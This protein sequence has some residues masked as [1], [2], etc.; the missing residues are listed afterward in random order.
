MRAIQL[1]RTSLVGAVC[2]SMIVSSVAAQEAGAAASVPAQATPQP[3]VA[4]KPQADGAWAQEL[5]LWQAAAAGNTPAEY[6]AYLD[7]YPQGKFASIAKSR[8][9]ALMAEEPDAVEDGQPTVVKAPA[10][11]S[12]GDGRTTAI[13]TPDTETYLLDR[14]TRREVQGR[15]TSL[16]FAT[17]GV[18][19]AFGP[20]S[21]QAVSQWQSVAGVPV[22]GFINYEQLAKLRADSAVIYPQWLASRPPVVRRPPPFRPDPEND[23]IVGRAP[24]DDSGDAA[25]ALGV[26]GAAAVVGVGIAASNNHH[27]HGRHYRGGGCR[28]RRWC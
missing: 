6:E 5:A 15:L 3:A 25:L 26:L 1:A 7:A 9:Q 23:E 17:G 20:R 13:G 27:H 21:R 2:L 14:T 11:P 16:G 4:A 24:R 18:D 12:A 22:T 8:T 28:H 10:A 19:G